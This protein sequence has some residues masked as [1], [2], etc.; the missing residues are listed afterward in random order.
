MYQVVYLQ[1]FSV[2][3]LPP[4][5]QMCSVLRPVRMDVNRNDFEGK[6][7]HWCICLAAPGERVS[8]DKWQHFDGLV[9]MC[10]SVDFKSC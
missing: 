5:L 10:S 4:P 6:V 9:K 3:F 8:I 7:H 2:E 1:I